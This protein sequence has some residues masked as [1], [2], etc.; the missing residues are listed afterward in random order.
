MEPG[1]FLGQAVAVL[2]SAAV[3]LWLSAVL[4]L[5]SVVGL[6]LSG[7]LIGPSGLA[8]V[9]DA[10]EVEIFAEIGVV[11][12]LFV[13]G[14]ELRL[15]E[16]RELGRPFLLGGLTQALL[17]T[18]IVGGVTYVLTDSWTTA[19]FVGW[20]V[21]LSSTAVVL[22]LYGER[23]EL[24]TPQGSA[25][26]SILLFQDFLVI[27][28]VVLTPLLAG[29]SAAS[30]R[31]FAIRFG[32]ALVAIVVVVVLARF[33][34]PQLLYLLVKTRVRELFVLSG[35]A[36][37]LLMS[38][39]TYSI[40]LSLALGAFLAGL[41]VSETEYS[42]LVIADLLPFRDVFASVFFVS[43]GMLV[44]LEYA[45]AELPLLLGLAVLVIVLK[46]A[47]TG[48]AAAI[49]GF[50]FRIALIAGLGLAQIGEFSFLLMEVGRSNGLLVDATY[51]MVLVTAVLTLLATPPLIRYAPAISE[52]ISNRLPF[53]VAKSDDEGKPEMANHVIVAGYGVGGRL[54]VGVLKEASIPHRVVELNAVTVRQALDEGIDIVHGDASRREM[55]EHLG[56]NRAQV[57]VLAI[58]DSAAARRT[59]QLTKVLNPG[60]EIL[61]RTQQVDE[62]EK[63]RE[64]GASTVV[65]EEFEAALEI[66]ARVLDR[67]HVP[68]NVIRAE[69]LALR[70][71]GYRM[72]RVPGAKGVNEAV[73]DALQ[74][75]TTDLYRINSGSF[76]EGKSLVDLDLRRQTGVSV[77]AVVRGERSFTNP[78][79]DI[80]LEKADCLVLVG[81]H[82]QIDSAFLYLGGG[83][84]P[85]P[86]SGANELS[87]S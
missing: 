45:L 47:A 55:L 65:A 35:L 84:V 67:F 41:L 10:H 51:Q 2:G 15:D 57:L 34:V 37:C 22:K 83:E 71:E 7:L 42:H 63:L 78:S 60:I 85:A 26:L 66:F 32:A 29:N 18:G 5:P 21:T 38:W 39:F 44:N 49:G 74:E 43:I 36:T 61:A 86:W 40:G 80:R 24:R 69:M 53:R 77:L 31:D 14:L 16:L 20:V 1:E 30:P 70:G 59:A 50:P 48:V 3:M 6:I 56:V 81:S 8:L 46:T 11:L 54:L 19:L 25:A 64:A 12:L 23:S 76:P 82:A 28:M 68:S 27:P 9:H 87:D 73:I 33:V 13:I 72:L 52:S 58:S 4:R 75:G 62:I 17:L 79:P